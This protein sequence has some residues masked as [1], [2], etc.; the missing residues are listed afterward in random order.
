MVG[1]ALLNT[2]SEADMERRAAGYGMLLSL[3][4]RLP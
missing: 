2:V 4:Y 3:T 1:G